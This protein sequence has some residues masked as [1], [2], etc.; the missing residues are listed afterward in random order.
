[1]TQERMTQERLEAKA[2]KYDS[3]IALALS[4]DTSRDAEMEDANDDNSN[5]DIAQSSRIGLDLD[6][7]KLK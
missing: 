3:A 4:H 1:M 5:H 6:T 2:M 7:E